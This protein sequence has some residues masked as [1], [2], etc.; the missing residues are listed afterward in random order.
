MELPEV[1]SVRKFKELAPEQ[2]DEVYETILELA[3]VIDDL[4]KKS[5]RKTLDL[6]LAILAYKGQ[7]VKELEAELDDKDQGS[8]ESHNDRLVDE[9]EKLK[10]MI[11]DLEDERLEYKRKIKELTEEMFSLQ[12]RLQ[13][14]ANAEGSDKDSSDPLSELDKQETLLRNINTKNKHI[15]R[16]LREIESLQNQNIEQSKTILTLEKDLQ[17][18]KE[19]VMK[20]KADITLL[21]SENSAH[22]ENIEEL[23][24]EIKRLEGQV[25]YLEDERDKSEAEV[26]EFVDKLEK[27]AMAWKKIIDEK[28]RQ[29]RKLK[30]RSERPEDAE[31]VRSSSEATKESEVTN[32]QE[33]RSRLL[34]SLECRDKLIEQLE[35]KIKTM[36]EEMIA[37]TKLMNKITAEREHE[38]NPNNPRPCCKT[39]EMALKT[40]NDKVRELTEMLERAEEECCLKAKQALEASNA[41]TAY[42]KGE[43]GLMTALRKCSSLENKLQSRD[44]QI[45]ALVMELNSLHEIAQENTL[46]RKRLNIPEDVIITTKNLT[47]KERNKE[48]MIEKLTLKLRASEEMRLQLKMEKCDLRKELLELQRQLNISPE[49]RTI[50]ENPTLTTT[51]PKREEQR[52]EVPLPKS[53]KIT[54]KRRNSSATHHNDATREIGEV[55]D[56]SNS[57]DASLMVTVCNQCNGNMRIEIQDQTTRDMDLKYQEALEENEILRQGMLE[58]LEKLREYDDCSDNITINDLL[59][60]RLIR[61]LKLSNSSRNSP[62]HLHNELQLLKEREK[63]LEERLTG[64]IPQITQQEMVVTNDQEENPNSED[65]KSLE[66]LREE[67]E[68]KSLQESSPLQLPQYLD[69]STRPTT[70]NKS[71]NIPNIQTPREPLDTEAQRQHE[72]DLDE[73]K[74]Y[75]K[76]YEELQ[77][78]MKASEGDLMQTC[79]QL[80]DK[81]VNLERDLSRE[82]KSS[83]YMR[84]D[85]DTT[86][87]NLKNLELQLI[88]KETNYKLEISALK[89]T[90]EKLE[91]ELEYHKANFSYNQEDYNDLQKSLQQSQTQLAQLIKEVLAGKYGNDLKIPD[92]CMD[93]G[94]IQDDLQLSFVTH[95]EFEIQKQTLKE[96]EAQ[97]SELQR[98]ISQLESLLEIAQ[99]QISSQQKLLNDITDNHINLRH[100]VADLQSSTEEKLLMAKI[101][102]DLDAAKSEINNLKH[103]R[104]TLKLQANTLQQ[105]LIS[106]ENANKDLTHSFQIERQNAN[107]KIKFLQKS[108]NCLREKYAKF[109]PL[110]FLT[111]F[112]FSYN[113]FL[114]RTSNPNSP[115]KKDN[116]EDIQQIVDTVLEE[117][118]QEKIG[119]MEANQQLIK[120]VKSETQCKLYEDQIKHLEKK[121][122]DLEKDLQE[123]KIR[124]ATESE[125]WH[126]IEALFGKDNG[127]KEND[128]VDEKEKTFK[129]EQIS[130]MEIGCNTEPLITSPPIPAERKLSAKSRRR[131]SIEMIDRNLSPIQTPT[132]RV[133][134]EVGTQT[135]D[136]NNQAKKVDIESPA[137]EEIKPKSPENRKTPTSTCEVEIQTCVPPLES[138][139]VQTLENDAKDMEKESKESPKETE[140][141]GALMKLQTT[142]ESLSEAQRQIEDLKTQLK[143]LNNSQEAQTPPSAATEQ[144]MPS[145]Q[146]DVIEKTILS[147]HTLL[148]E[149]DK[150]IGKYQ[151][152]LQAEREQAHL[153]V[154]KLTGEIDGLKNTITNLNFNIK[155]KDIEILELKTQLETLTERRNS[156]EKLE[157]ARSVPGPE[158]NVDNSLHEMTDEKIE[159]LFEENLSPTAGPASP[160]KVA[161]ASVT[162]K[163]ELE[164]VKDIPENYS[165]QLRELK[166]KAS[167]WE[168]TLKVKEDEIAILREKIRLLDERDKTP[169]NN[170]LEIEQLRSL[171][172]EKDRHINELMDTLNNFH[173]DQQRYINDSS[174]YSADQIA[175]LASDLTRTEATNKIYQTQVEAMRKQLANLAQREKQ[176]RELNQ[177]L[178]QQLI[179]R[180]VVSIKT[181]LNARVKNENLQKRLQQLELDL[182]E[183]RAEIQRQKAII[184]SKRARSANE[185]GLWEKQKRWQQSAEKY[186]AKLEETE[187]MLEKTRSLL[188]SARTTINRL[189]K[190]KQILEA[191]L[192]R[193]TQ[194]HVQNSMKCCRTPSCPNLHHHGSPGHGSSGGGGG[195]KYTPSESPETYTGASSECSSPGRCSSIQQPC[196]KTHFSPSASV[197][198]AHDEIIQALK[199]RI[200]MQQRKILA[201]ELEGKGSNA[202]TTEMEKLQEKLSAIEAQNIRLEAKN[203][204]LQLDNDLLRQGDGTERLQKRIKHLEDYIIALKEERASSE[205]RRELCKCNGL[206]VNIQSGQSAEHTIISLRNIV[207]KLKA[208]NKYLKDGRRSCESRI[209]MD[210]SGPDSARLQQMYSESMD[211]I[212]TLQME[213]KQ[214]QQQNKCP[215]CENKNKILDNPSSLTSSSLQDELHYVKG[216]LIKKTQLLQK[217]K[218]L[219]TRAAAKEKVLKEQ[220]SMWKRKCSELQNVPVIDEISE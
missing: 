168:S 220:L 123:M 56:S 58:I 43:D 195:G 83:A 213:L 171:L 92:M 57:A 120:L 216:Q 96:F 126:T 81:V 124:M 146:S 204:Q 206:K 118:L 29:L 178:R 13:E 108:L 127:N 172:E 152:L 140:L 176:A 2:K 94:I 111:N 87:N 90:I 163:H 9:N 16:L 210:N 136:L 145:L 130:T 51:E 217:A 202:L 82:T 215:H 190:D 201:L 107:I 209:S 37:S 160:V 129:E 134:K 27:K 161:Q 179:K 191:K 40:S 109:T 78:H 49:A 75:K 122:F 104:D 150:S 44:K 47:A 165:K 128:E 6:T 197:Q 88:D 162:E 156:N 169:A 42:Q 181:E 173:D 174:N 32:E 63:A 91:H 66:S 31:S 177:S 205:A 25:T 167:Y 219:L 119:H 5:L 76:Y 106:R 84:Q 157:L 141:K 17:H 35:L 71:I 69:S 38:R 20:L 64:H 99:D 62:K 89:A 101:Q 52:A 67:G 74:I 132:K 65:L 95:Q 194:Q 24:I 7:Q 102:R 53:P 183:A 12:K 98:K 193:F 3:R 159:E 105:D 198:E 21:Q 182:E 135:E 86:L 212:A 45:R 170:N 151:D 144:S 68:I 131:S 33:E 11:S 112:V 137:K 54:P 70:P 133:I 147:F 138:K 158:E 114:Q 72:L 110:V 211:K 188:Q 125:H 97:R 28:D 185:V 208:E 175:K 218:V 189:E 154:G 48:K 192:S 207:E 55:E 180:P 19:S 116:R 153:N 85:F 93:Y 46:L 4:P 139:T 73:M 149:K 214:Q 113:K 36:A 184:E 200:E 22:K 100:L 103:E 15:K 26:K 10:R 142:E 30:E 164:G 199:A 8:L 18:S 34:H 80:T 61:A 166:E 187:V 77:L 23:N 59:L 39:I 60:E 14:A 50:S 186:K 41:L 1:V 79:A 115:L 203:L 148:S 196:G 155:T 117:L 121:C 143:S